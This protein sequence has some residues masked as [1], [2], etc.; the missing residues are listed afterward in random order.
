M[1]TRPALQDAVHYRVK[2]VKGHKCALVC[3][4]DPVAKYI[5][6]GP[7]I[8]LRR[9]FRKLMIISPRD[10][11]THSF[12]KSLSR[13]KI[14][15]T[16]HLENYY[17][18][19]HPFSDF[20]FIWQTIMT[21]TH[22]MILIIMP[23]YSLGKVSKTNL[24]TQKRMFR[25][26]LALDSICWMNIL[27]SFIIG[28][29][30]KKN[31]KIILFPKKIIVRYLCT[32]FVFDFISTL[33]YNLFFGRIFGANWYT[34]FQW[35]LKLI[36]LITINEYLDNVQL[37]LALPNFLYRSFKYTL[38]TTVILLW[39]MFVD[40]AFDYYYRR[41]IIHI[42]LAHKF[43]LAADN[44]LRRLFLVDIYK[45]QYKYITPLDLYV[46]FITLQCGKIF[47]IWLLAKIS[48][49]FA[50]YTMVTLRYQTL[51]HQIKAY[52]RFKDL[53]KRMSRRIYSYINFRFQYYI[54]NEKTLMDN[55]CL[56]LKKQ[57]LWHTCQNLVTK[58]ETFK[59]LPPAVLMK[60]V[61]M[62]KPE[63]YLPNDVVVQAGEV[64]S[65]M[66]FIYVGVLA[67]FT[68]S[69]KEICHL[70]DGTHFGEIALLL[71]EPR[72]ASV[73]AIDFC[74]L[75]RLTKKDFNEAIEPYP[76]VKEKILK[77]AYERFQETRN[78][79][80]K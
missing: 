1:A 75:Y 2:R 70:S 26:I 8:P 40:Y 16:R 46:S 18:I 69:G 21:L 68:E 50:S 78:I 51:I 76:A 37:R 25:F 74:E 63:I 14:E 29:H 22:L 17:Y 20:H 42:D 49:I 28:Y 19:I 3:E 23:I 15:E 55:L 36:R 7:F 47:E 67:V 77:A 48:Q 45:G 72:V 58:V 54:F 32:H 71:N 41:V 27:L 31:D 4:A 62:I 24:T 12:A 59:E 11:R 43:F 53:P 56:T 66:F 33:N 80:P 73:V 6:S 35:A 52:I 13:I 60:L 64:G 10:P 39:L 38:F 5:K 9:K 61:T 44:I 34:R 57:I 65:E 79:S 30:N